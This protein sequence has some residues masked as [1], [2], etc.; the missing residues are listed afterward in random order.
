MS[1]ASSGT[2][3]VRETSSIASSRPNR[4]SPAPTST[5]SPNERLRATGIPSAPRETTIVVISSRALAIICARKSS[6]SRGS[7]WASSITSTGRATAGTASVASHAFS[8]PAGS[9]RP[10]SSPQATPAAFS[11]TLNEIRSEMPARPASQRPGRPSAVSCSNQ[12]S[13]ALV[14]PLPAGAMML[15]TREASIASESAVN[16]GRSINRRRLRGG[17][18]VVGTNPMSLS[19]SFASAGVPIVGEL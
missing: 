19:M 1:S 2:P 4:R 11:A 18:I 14:L 3:A 7:I 8:L 15:V 12:N 9:S 5:I 6:T 17:T 16:A 13:A 10:Q